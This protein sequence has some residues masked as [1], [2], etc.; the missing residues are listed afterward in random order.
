M[1]K[2]KQKKLHCQYWLRNVDLDKLNTKDSYSLVQMASFRR[3]VANFVFFTTG[4]TIPVKYN[5]SGTMS[6][7]DLD[8]QKVVISA[9]FKNQEIDGIIGVA[10][11][12]ASHI[13]KTDPKYFG[14]ETYSIDEEKIAK[15]KK[16]IPLKVF[17]DAKK[18]LKME[19][20]DVVQILHNLLNWIEDRRID[21]WE[22]ERAPGYQP[23]YQATYKKYFRSPI[24]DMGLMSTSYRDEAVASYMYRIVNFLNRNTDL[25][26]LKG[27]KEIW[28]IIQ[29]RKIS[30][31][32]DTK[33]AY[34]T[35]L[36]V[37]NVITKYAKSV[38]SKDS[39]KKQGD[40]EAG[41]GNPTEDLSGD[42]WEDS[43]DEYKPDPIVLSDKEFDKLLKDIESGKARTGK[44]GQPIKLT[45][46]Q[47]EK[48]NKMIDKQNDFLEN[49]TDKGQPLSGE[50]ADKLEKVEKS[51]TSIEDAHTKPTK[52]SKISGAGDKVPVIVV[53]NL[54]ESNISDTPMSYYGT[55]AISEDAVIAGVQMG[56]Q[57]AKRLIVRN[58]SRKT[59]LTRKRTGRIDK[60]LLHGCGYG[61]ESIF[62]QSYIDQ[63][64]DA[65]IHISVDASSSMNS[66]EK[67]GNALKTCVAIAKAAELVKNLDVVVS[68][69]T[70]A[71][72]EKGVLPYV[73]IAYDSRKDKFSKVRSLFPRL[74]PNNYTPEGMCFEAIMQ[75][76][77]K[78][79]AGKD[80][81]FINFSDGE[82]YCPSI[83][84]SNKSYGGDPA[85]A[86]TRQ[87][88]NKM[89]D[90]GIKILSFF[91]QGGHWSSD[92]EDFK[93]SYGADGKSINTNS[94]VAVARE[95][96]KMYSGD[97]KKM[98]KSI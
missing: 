17:A 52:T 5:T 43:G 46:E 70:T 73:L 82:P 63:F 6:F 89:K 8:E 24:I 53:R 76:I 15:L 32:K 12:E 19:E 87:Q 49:G 74:S 45:K 96:N 79:S 23:Y 28:D 16:F 88:V 94:I 98:R 93:K 67:W 37:W 35:A 48:L 42:G 11:H 20:K 92:P 51:G 86:Q 84:Y 18:K 27:L 4:K 78:S 26:A 39:D 97:D 13:V 57:L 61:C 44:G 33:D 22:M 38:E 14:Y 90:H 21:Y 55:N 59:V 91:I 56:R 41:E 10:L 47:Q 31:L 30:R 34:D 36:K 25:T 81:M 75:E 68:F 64:G 95:L 2:S 29:L 72:G 54:T 66:T 7:A 65:I 80:S 40:G 3:A 83:A 71:D 9:D 1:K 85:H 50:E 62:Q 58:E 60:R 77:I 69:R